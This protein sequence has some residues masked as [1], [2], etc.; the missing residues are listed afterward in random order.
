[1]GAEKGELKVRK[2]YFIVGS[3]GLSGHEMYKKVHK[4]IDE[5]LEM[6]VGT[7]FLEWENEGRRGGWK[8]GWSLLYL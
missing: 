7:H 4:R 6:C 8:L 2:K 3:G 5:Y 1:M